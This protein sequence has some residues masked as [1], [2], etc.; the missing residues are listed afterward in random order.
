MEI[1][2]LKGEFKFS[3][4]AVPLFEAVYKE[5][6]PT[7]FDDEATTSYKTSKWAQ[8][9]K[10]AMCIS[11]ARGESLVIS[12]DDF[13][14]AYTAVNKV[15]E[16]LNKVFRAVG[17]SDLVI[18]SDK[19]LRLLEEKGYASR[20]ELIHALWRDVT[21]DELDKILLTFR[22]GGVLREVTQGNQ[23]R[24]ALIDKKP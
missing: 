19:V 6:T 17:E 9:S 16:N 23:I 13:E 20:K 7:E 2:R 12:K 22:E 11:A 8:V 4:A 14:L 15:S 18:A 10:V 21:S 1:G 3:P 5:S 24:Y